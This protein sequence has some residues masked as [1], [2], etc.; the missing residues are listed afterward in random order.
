MD[1]ISI[2]VPQAGGTNYLTDPRN[3]QEVNFTT[4][5]S[6]GEVESGGPVMNIVPKSGGNKLSA[7][8]FFSW[9]NG[10]LQGNNLSDEL[11]A[12]RITPSPLIK[13]Y[14]MTARWASRW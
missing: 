11:K 9:A 6:L 14:D 12:Q 5:G 10:D 8:T 7:S 2:A 3:S 4:S 13:S 1:G